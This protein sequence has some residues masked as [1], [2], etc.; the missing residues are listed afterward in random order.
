MAQVDLVLAITKYEMDI[1]MMMAA[2]AVVGVR[3]R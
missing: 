1:M 3:R 2:V